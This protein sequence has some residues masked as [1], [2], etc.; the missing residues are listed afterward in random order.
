MIG[1]FCDRWIKNLSYKVN[2]IYN[3]NKNDVLEM[4]SLIDAISDSEQFCFSRSDI[5]SIMNSF[6]QNPLIRVDIWNQSNN[7]VF[8][9]SIRDND[10]DIGIHTEIFEDF[11]EISKID[12]YK[13][14]IFVVYCMERKTIRKTIY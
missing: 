3:N 4:N 11:F 13:V 12:F 5:D 8:D 14:F 7:I 9:T 1:S 10:N 6:G 2:D